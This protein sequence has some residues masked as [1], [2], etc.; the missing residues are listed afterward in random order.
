MS[1]STDRVERLLQQE[2][3]KNQTTGQVLSPVDRVMQSLQQ[4]DP[5]ASMVDQALL[6]GQEPVDDSAGFLANVGAGV[7]DQPDTEIS[8]WQSLWALANANSFVF[9]KMG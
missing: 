6:A 8:G 9:E 2:K 1:V 5:N 4:P 3:E 7:L